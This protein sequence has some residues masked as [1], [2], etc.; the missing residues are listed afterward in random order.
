VSSPFAPRPFRRMMTSISMMLLIRWSHFGEVQVMRVLLIAGLFMVSGVLC[1]QQPPEPTAAADLFLPSIAN[2]SAEDFCIG[3]GCYFGGPHPLQAEVLRDF[4]SD[5]LGNLY[6]QERQLSYLPQCGPYAMQVVVLLRVSPVGVYEEVGRFGDRCED[7]VYRSI[8][9]RGVGI[10]T[11]NGHLHAYAD[12]NN[13][14]S[15]TCHL[16]N[17]VI[18]ISGLPTLLDIILSY[19]PP[20]TLSFNVPVRP[21]GLVGAASFSV[22]AGDVRT[23]SDLTQATPLECSV[24]AGRPH[25]PGEQLTVADTLPDPAAGAGRYYVAAVKHGDQIRA[26]RSMI[27]GVMQG[28]NAAVLPVCQ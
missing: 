24:P 15:G 11:V 21:E 23:A 22:Y 27:G 9:L 5:A 26:G 13:C 25:I 1:A 7:G 4:H 17:A 18:R 28:R 19:Q 14:A 10:D 12:L 2:L 16:R 8:S 20:S 3:Q 6:Y